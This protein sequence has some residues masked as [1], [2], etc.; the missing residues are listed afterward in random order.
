MG[1]VGRNGRH[2]RSVIMAWAAAAVVEGLLV[3]PVAPAVPSASVAVIS[4]SDAPGPWR[5]GRRA[6]RRDRG[7][8]VAAT[9]DR[10][11]DEAGRAGTRRPEQGGP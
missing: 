11:G 2:R 5:D 4:G 8:P 7:G 3:T 10:W 1:P 6:A 9:G